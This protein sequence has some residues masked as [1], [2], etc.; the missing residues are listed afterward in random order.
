M[1]TACRHSR[2]I[3]RVPAAQ[4]ATAPVCLRGLLSK[5]YEWNNGLIANCA[6]PLNK[7]A[8]NFQLVLYVGSVF[9]NCLRLPVLHNSDLMVLPRNRIS[10]RIIQGIV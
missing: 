3:P 2:C 1:Q 7:K 6:H 8:R 5:D 10:L 4:P 9:E